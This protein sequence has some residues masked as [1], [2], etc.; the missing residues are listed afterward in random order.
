[1]GTITLSVPDEM[2]AKMDRIEWIN[3][4]S[5]ARRAFA[6][7]L[8]DAVKL[9]AIKRA[10]EI[11][12][13]EDSDERDFNEEYKKELESIVKGKHTKTFSPNELTKWFDSL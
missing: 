12:E 2:K 11:S 10:R 13:I 8:L 5:I 4:S 7:A 3:W 6:S 9:E 1:M